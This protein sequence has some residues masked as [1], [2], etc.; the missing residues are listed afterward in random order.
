MELSLP[1]PA[2][3][4]LNILVATLLQEFLRGLRAMTEGV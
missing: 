1:S 4:E 2:V 3:L